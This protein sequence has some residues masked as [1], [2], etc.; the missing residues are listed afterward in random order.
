MN[1]ITAALILAATI[2]GLLGLAD[3]IRTRRHHD[4]R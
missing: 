2:C 1:Y 3:L 4:G